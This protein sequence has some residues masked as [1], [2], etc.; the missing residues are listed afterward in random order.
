MKMSP[1]RV[2]AHSLG[3][4]AIALATAS[5]LVVPVLVGASRQGIPMTGGTLASG[6]A[7]TASIAYVLWACAWT[8]PVLMGGTTDWLD[9]VG[10]PNPLLR[11]SLLLVSPLVLAAS[12]LYGVAGGGFRELGRMHR[13]AAR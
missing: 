3:S 4:V 8:L 7:V 2:R 9:R 12:I 1:Q 6:T 10:V 11:A 13:L 5:F